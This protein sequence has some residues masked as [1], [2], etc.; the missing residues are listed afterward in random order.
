LIGG[1]LNK[2]FA[3]LFSTVLLPLGCTDSPEGASK[4]GVVAQDSSGVFVV[5]LSGDIRRYA[6]PL[7]RLEPVVRIGEDESGLELFRVSA[8]RFLPS[9][10]LAIAN[11]GVPELLLVDL[12]GHLLERIGDRGEGPGQFGTITS[13]HIEGDGSVVTFDDRQARLTRFDASGEVLETRRM[14]EP[15]S[16][17]DLIP[18]SASQTGPVLAVYGDNRVFGRQGTRQ[19]TTPL[20]RF[21][22]ESTR[23][24]TLSLWPMK[25]WYF[26]P[27]GQG[28]SRVQ[29]PFSPNLLSAGGGSRAALA[30]THRSKVSVFGENGDLIMSVR[31]DEEP[32]E[33][34]NSEYVEWQDERR[35]GM[36]EEIP[37]AVQQALVEI[38][39]HET[40]PV[41][42][43]LHVDGEGRV[44]LAPASMLSGGDQTWIQLSTDGQPRGAVVLPSS[45]K[46]LDAFGERIAVL[47]RN[48]LGVE[49]IV[50]H[51]ITEGG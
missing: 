34:S 44:W 20:L 32:R 13:L 1:D 28:V 42:N 35:S 26:S 12:D 24:D 8:A 29:V 2:L 6:E 38:P 3:V 39:H 10:T 7:R 37:K 22:S 51:R 5:R 50:I 4:K 36:P 14:S 11:A 45:A 25:T 15:S 30:N 46:I 49:F 33:V 18:L 21:T 31:W 9:G 27:T 19:D 48:E 47:E 23:P 41:I 40:H 43:S 17:A 16:I